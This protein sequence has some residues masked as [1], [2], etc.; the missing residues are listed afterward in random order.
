MPHPT[1][2]PRFLRLQWPRHGCSVY[3]SEEVCRT[4]AGP[5]RS[6]EPP[7]AA[8]FWS[9]QAGDNTGFQVSGP[10]V[11]QPDAPC[12]GGSEFG[13]RCQQS[14]IADKCLFKIGGQSLLLFSREN[15]GAGQYGR[16]QTEEEGVDM[17]LH[18]LYFSAVVFFELFG[19][20]KGALHTIKALYLMEFKNICCQAL[21]AVPALPSW[22]EFQGDIVLHVADSLLVLLG[23]L[24]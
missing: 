10:A 4:K 5:D 16:N 14:I 1:L 2:L 18:C 11:P 9:R 21:I 12:R 23:Q 17:S 7:V 20:E 22:P 24:I 8:R 15:R 19:T 6:P 13:T 3:A